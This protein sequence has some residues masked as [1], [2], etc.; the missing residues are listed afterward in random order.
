[1]KTHQSIS[2][3]RRKNRKAH[4]AAPSHIRYRLMSS[5]LSKEL[6]AKYNVRS[7][8]LRRDDE[9]Q[10]MR[11]IRKGEKGKISQVYRKRFAIYIEKIV[12][13][14]KN[15]APTRIP[16][17]ASNVMLT[18]LK[19]TPDRQDLINRKAAGRGPAAKGKLT[20]KDVKA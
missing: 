4:F 8:P 14:K 2:S 17:Q 20:D 19:I 5:L 11:G 15:N 16:I 7:L 1:M 9:V 18:K 10:I 6:R 13:K 12:G 3:S